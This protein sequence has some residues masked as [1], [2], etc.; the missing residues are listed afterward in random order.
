[1]ARNRLRKGPERIPDKGVL[2]TYARLELPRRDEGF[3]ALFF[4][5]MTN[6]GFDVEE[7]QT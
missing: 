4:V 3:D 5:R 1:M 7:W 6:D 2:G